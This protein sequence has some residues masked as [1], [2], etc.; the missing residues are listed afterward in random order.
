LN[1]IAGAPDRLSDAALLAQANGDVEFYR[2]H[3]A[4]WRGT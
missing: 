3:A 4:G 2:R 1:G